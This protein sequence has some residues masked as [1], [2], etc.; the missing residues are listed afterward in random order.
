MDKN[1]KPQKKPT[2]IISSVG[3]TLY[4]R[5]PGYVVEV[6][7]Q[8]GS[9]KFL[10]ESANGCRTVEQL[11]ELVVGRYPQVTYDSLANALAQLDTNG[12]LEDGAA[13]PDGLLDTYELERWDRNLSFFEAFSNTGVSKFELQHRLKSTKVAL[14]GLGGVGSHLLYD[15]A[16]MGIQDI[17]AVDFDRVE[18]SNL[19]RQV[20]YSEADAGRPKAEAAAERILAFSPRIKLETVSKHLSST[21]D[22][23][24]VIGDRDYVLCVA[25]QPRT[26]I[27]HWVNDACVRQH[28]TLIIG[29][30]D[31]ERV[32]YY[33]VVPGVTG[34]VECWLRQVQERDPLSS[35]LIDER[36]RAQIFLDNGTFAPPISVL[37]GLMLCEL[38]RLVAGIEPP[39]A[40]G[41]LMEF[42]FKGSTIAE[43]ER[44]ER[45]ADCSTCGGASQS[46]SHA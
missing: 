22:I 7:D 36:R 38:T 20:L 6:P 10:L 34:C 40:A 21:E 18:L 35:A 16:A 30:H 45:L 42:C 3:S 12:F 33:T 25:D 29:G 37:A 24:D 13:T 9:I 28:A 15:L 23:M 8:T 44:W 11:H 17:R 2:V 1:A 27:V 31:M 4:F 14:L 19:N 46:A 41:R 43:A 26:E 32:V 39:V 5:K